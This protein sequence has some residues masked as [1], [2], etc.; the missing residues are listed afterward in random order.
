VLG[1]FCEAC[2]LIIYIEEEEAFCFC[3]HKIATNKCRIVRVEQEK[4]TVKSLL[5]KGEGAATL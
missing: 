2:I 1:G 4:K 3:F 5:K